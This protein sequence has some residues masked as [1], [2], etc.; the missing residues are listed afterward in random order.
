[1]VTDSDGTISVVGG[2]SEGQPGEEEEEERNPMGGS[3]DVEETAEGKE[4]QVDSGGMDSEADSLG[5]VGGCFMYAFVLYEYI[6]FLRGLICCSFLKGYF[7]ISI[8][9]LCENIVGIFSM[10]FLFVIS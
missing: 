8:L 3:G 6:Y 10:K 2:G 1:M 4:A 9:F 5:Q 7:L